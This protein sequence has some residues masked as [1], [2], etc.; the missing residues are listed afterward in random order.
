VSFAVDETLNCKVA[1]VAAPTINGIAISLFD[2]NL[3]WQ[4]GCEQY[5]AR[6]LLTRR[7]PTSRLPA[8][9]NY[10]NQSAGNLLAV[11]VTL[12]NVPALSH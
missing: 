12:G 10:R 3:A 5:A 8:S 2:S 7:L 11:A 6:R 9:A 4:I 1:A